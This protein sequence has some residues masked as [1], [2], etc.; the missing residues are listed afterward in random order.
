MRLEK[1]AIGFE[2]ILIYMYKLTGNY[3][4]MRCEVSCRGTYVEL[5]SLYQTI[6]RLE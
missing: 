1:K 2:N 3:L 4:D 6:F 5:L